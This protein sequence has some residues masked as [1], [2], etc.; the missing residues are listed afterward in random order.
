MSPGLALVKPAPAQ[1]SIYS[2]EGLVSWGWYLHEAVGLRMSS[3]S[4]GATALHML[5]P[6]S[7][8]TPHVDPNVST[9]HE[10]KLCFSLPCGWSNDEPIVEV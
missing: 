5:K 2:L 9:D 10:A 8:F 7:R 4:N 1:L 6:V 3:S